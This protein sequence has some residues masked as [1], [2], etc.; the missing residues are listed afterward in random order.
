M[1]NI[2]ITENIEPAIQEKKQLNSVQMIDRLHQFVD[3]LKIIIS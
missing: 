3:I 2:E 1:V